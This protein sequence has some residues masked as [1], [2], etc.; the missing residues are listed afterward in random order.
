MASANP[1]NLTADWQ[2]ERLHLARRRGGLCAGCG[3][4]LSNG[5][6]I[7]IEQFVDDRGIKVTAPVGVE[8][9]S[10]KL[11]DDTQGQEPEH[12]AWCG[13]GVFY[14]A[15]HWKRQQALC[16]RACAARVDAAKNRKKAEG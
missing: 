2:R 11:L 14:R 1:R 12:C 4:T 8:C 5:E 16:S 13:R 7:Y 10:E 9:T 6:T 3:R 15:G